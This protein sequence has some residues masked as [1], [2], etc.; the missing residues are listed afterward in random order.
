M[1]KY[2][3]GKTDEKKLV[4]NFAKALK[5]DE[6][7]KVVNELIIDDN[8]K[9]RYTSSLQEVAEINK[10]CANCKGLDYL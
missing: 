4:D 10:T 7:V 5:D 3:F 6:F 2:S 1:E 9:Y 8:I